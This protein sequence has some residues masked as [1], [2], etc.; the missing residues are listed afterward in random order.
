[1]P[2]GEGVLTVNLGLPLIV[3]CTKSDLIQSNDKGIFTEHSLEAL[4]RS[5]RTS[6]LLC[7]FRI[8]ISIDGASTIFVS[9]KAQINIE[10]FYHYLMHR[11]YDYP[12][13]FKALVDEKE[14]VF[15][16]T[17]FD[18]LTLIKYFVRL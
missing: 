8:V 1:L 15:I 11:V 2:L 6:A 4:N 7:I 10:L 12:F 13:K 14:R 16:P 9:E 3:L 5:V 17:G 18:S